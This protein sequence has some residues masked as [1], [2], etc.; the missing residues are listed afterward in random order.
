[1]VFGALA[2]AAKS[3]IYNPFIYEKMETILFGLVVHSDCKILLSTAKITAL[4]QLAACEAR[5]LLGLCGF[6][7]RSMKDWNDKNLR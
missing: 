2:P 5:F 1:M 4:Y 3:C 7:V 6:F